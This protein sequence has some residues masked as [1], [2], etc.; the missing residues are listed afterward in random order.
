MKYLITCVALIVLATCA[1][2]EYAWPTTVTKPTH[3]TINDPTAGFLPPPNDVYANWKNAGLAV[4]GGI[5]TRNTQCGATVITTGKIPPT[6]GDDAS[7][8]NAAITACPAGDFVLLGPG[9]TSAANVSITANALTLNS[10]S[11]AL[12]DVLIGTNL[13]PG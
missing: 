12:G 6:S 9:G 1:F 13:Q 2:N 4:I 10:G 8:I 3:I 11:I 7:V 5:P